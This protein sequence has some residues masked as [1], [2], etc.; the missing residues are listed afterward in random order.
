M[1]QVFCI[2]AALETTKRVRRYNVSISFSQYRKAQ[3]DSD[4]GMHSWGAWNFLYNLGL[5]WLTR[6]G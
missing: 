3:S 2:A 5:E 1:L 4:P 6:S